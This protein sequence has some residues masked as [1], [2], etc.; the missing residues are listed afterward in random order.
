MFQKTVQVGH[1]VFA[2]VDDRRYL[3]GVVVGRKD[4]DFVVR[5]VQNDTPN[6]KTCHVREIFPDQALVENIAVSFSEGG[7]DGVGSLRGYR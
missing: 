7:E 6:S 3:P 2:C 5:I 4:K 1:L